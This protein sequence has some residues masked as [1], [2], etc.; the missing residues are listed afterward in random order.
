M[1]K[2]LSRWVIYADGKY[3]DHAET[4]SKARSLAYNWHNRF[5]DYEKDM[6]YFPKMTIVKEELRGDYEDEFK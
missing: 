1:A 2:V 4:E 5:W 3:V 6:P